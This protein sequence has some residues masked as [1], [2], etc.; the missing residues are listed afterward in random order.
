MNA[1]TRDSRGCTPLMLAAEQGYAEVA[2]VLVTAG[3]D[4]SIPDVTGYTPLHCACMKGHLEIATI[5]LDAGEDVNNNGHGCTPV[6]VAADNGHAHLVKELIRR[7]A[8][9]TS[10]TE[11]GT[12]GILA[13]CFHGYLEVF[14]ELVRTCKDPSVPNFRGHTPL[15][16]AAQEGH[17]DLVREFLELGPRRYGGYN[18]IAAATCMAATEEH[19]EVLKLLAS[20]GGD[21]RDGSALLNASMFG[22]KQSVA[23]LL[24]VNGGRTVFRNRH[25]AT[26]LHHAAEVG[27]YKIVRMLLDAGACEYIEDGFGET[28]LYRAAQPMRIRV[29]AEGPPSQGTHAKQACWRIILQTP[30]IRARSWLWCV[31]TSVDTSPATRWNTILNAQRLKMSTVR[32]KGKEWRSAHIFAGACR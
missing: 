8:N 1:N 9:P 14:R 20:V 16:A 17:V 18:A 10:Q 27:H 12:T 2:R 28:A 23:F 11:E 24:G 3:A 32:R 26:P 31:T 7:G 21:D 5:L 29:S 25:G 15:G 19:M 22:K 13:A 6:Y 4:V 30:A